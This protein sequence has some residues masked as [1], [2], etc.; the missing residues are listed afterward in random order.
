[1]KQ[2]AGSKQADELV[3]YPVQFRRT[4]KT[5][6]AGRGFKISTLSVCGNEN[7]KI[8]I[9]LGG[10]QEVPDSVKKSTQDAKANM[11]QTSL[12]NTTVYH[13]IT[14]YYGATKLIIKPASRG[15]GIIAGGALRQFF[16]AMGVSDISVKCI[17]STN[18]VNVLR[19]AM[20]AIQQIHKP[21]YYAAKRGIS[22]SEVINGASVSRISE[23]QNH[24]E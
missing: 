14:A 17:G 12:N 13:R 7:G 4:A 5:S 3:S 18:P 1:M 15:S 2:Q 8:G 24:D 20:K 10:A 6:K 19:A 21:S 9:G 16:S 11:V 23:V 22:V